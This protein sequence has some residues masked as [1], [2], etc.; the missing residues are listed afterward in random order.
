MNIMKSKFKNV[1]PNGADRAGESYIVVEYLTD[2]K[3]MVWD[4]VKYILEK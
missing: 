2:E 1:K 3:T 4:E